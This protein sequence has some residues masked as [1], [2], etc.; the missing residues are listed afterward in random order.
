MVKDTIIKLVVSKTTDVFK[1]WCSWRLLR[2]PW[3]M[4]RSNQS[5]RKEINPE[6]PLGRL[7]LKLQYFGCLMW[8][9]KSLENT[10]M[11]GKIESRRKREWQRIR[12]LDDITKSIDMSLSKLRE[13]VNDREPGML[14]SMGP[15]R[16]RHNLATEHQQDHC[17]RPGEKCKNL[18]SL[19]VQVSMKCP[20]CLAS[21]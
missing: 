3:R 19:H 13:I 5:I 7:M 6:Y 20:L 15:P 10:L 16:V 9:A 11:L 12:W 21:V 1:L 17:K 8:R 18:G 4:K 2:V 14:Q